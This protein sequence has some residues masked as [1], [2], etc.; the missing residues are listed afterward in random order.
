[1]KQQLNEIKRM[2]E[3]AGVID[4]PSMSDLK[5]KKL[6]KANSH[7][8]LYSSIISIPAS[9]ANQVALGMELIVNNFDCAPNGGV[10]FDIIEYLKQK[11]K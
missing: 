6:L 1:M 3:L 2:Q 10:I 5:L 9:Y 7:E 8:S 11:T 4:K